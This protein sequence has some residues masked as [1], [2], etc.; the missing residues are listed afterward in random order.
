MK[1]IE[2]KCHL[3]VG[4]CK[5]ESIWAKIGDI[6]IW[7]SSKQKLL[8]VHVDTAL[9]FHEHVSNL[10]KKTGG[11]LSV[12]KVAKLYNS[13]IK[14]SPNELSTSLDVSC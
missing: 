5:H 1:L 8:E 13:N 4:L 3:L 14:K 9:Y 12:F 6:R 11:K 10:F 2:G 7:K